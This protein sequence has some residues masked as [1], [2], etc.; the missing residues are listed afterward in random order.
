MTFAEIQKAIEDMLAVQRELKQS[1]LTDKESKIQVRGNQ[2]A[3]NPM[4]CQL[5]E[6][7]QKYSDLAQYSVRQREIMDRLIELRKNYKSASQ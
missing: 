7:T 6:L 1:L 2:G 4:L 5:H 3:Q